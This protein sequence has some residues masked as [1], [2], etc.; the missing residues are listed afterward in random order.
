[1]Y[2]S[3]VKEVQLLKVDESKSGD[4]RTKSGLSLNNKSNDADHH[5]SL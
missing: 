2:D 4:E 3:L 5:T 1:M